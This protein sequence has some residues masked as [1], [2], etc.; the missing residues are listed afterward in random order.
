MRTFVKIMFCLV[1]TL[2]FVSFAQAQTTKT[3]KGYFCSFSEGDGGY[4]T[5]NVGNKMMIF[6]DYADSKIHAKYFGIKDNNTRNLK[7]GSEI[8][9]TYVIK[10]IYQKPDNLMR[11]VT[12]RKKVKQGIQVCGDD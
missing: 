12:F 9:V 11:T 7:V 8:V 6:V 3:A 5:M 10:T 2:M 1:F 4:L